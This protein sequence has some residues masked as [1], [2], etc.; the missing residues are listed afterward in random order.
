L[1]EL[2]RGVKGARSTFM[3]LET[4]TDEELDYLEREFERLRNRVEKRDAAP[5]NLEKAGKPQP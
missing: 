4:L 1:D 3:C 5:G 2:L